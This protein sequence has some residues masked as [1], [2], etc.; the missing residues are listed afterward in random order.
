MGH[1][2]PY[3]SVVK[4]AL[5]EIGSPSWSVEDLHACEDSMTDECEWEQSRGDGSR[6]G[7]MLGRWATLAAVLV[8]V[9]ALGLTAAG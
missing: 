4:R 1:F 2:G 8:I 3:E 6:G 9:L 5:A 7:A